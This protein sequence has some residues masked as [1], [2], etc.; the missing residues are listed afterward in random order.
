MKSDTIAIAMMVKTPGLSSIKT[1]LA[2][3]IGNENALRFYKKS[4]AVLSVTLE[5]LSRKGQFQPYYAFAEVDAGA[6]WNMFPCC[7]QGEGDLGHRLDHV[8]SKLLSRHKAV[9]VIGSDLPQ[10]SEY[11][12]AECAEILQTDA[13]SFC[14]GPTEDGGFYLMGGGAKIPTEVWINTP[15]SNSKTKQK[16]CER[17]E[18]HGKISELKEQFDIDEEKDLFKFQENLESFTRSCPALT[19]FNDFHWPE[20]KHHAHF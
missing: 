6:H 16:L 18:K 8:Y 11:L 20:R 2:A 4:V 3:T 7:Y 9:I 14:L 19:L 10:L 17:L 13:N 12:L 5:Q 1:R 15:Y